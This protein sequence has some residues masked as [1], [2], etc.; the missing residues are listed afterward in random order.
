MMKKCICSI[1][2]LVAIIVVVA[3]LRQKNNCQIVAEP[4]P[5]AGYTDQDINNLALLCKIWGFMK[6]YHPSIR[7]GEYDWDKELFQIMPEMVSVQSVEERNQKLTDWVEKFHCQFETAT[8]DEYKKHAKMYPDILWIENRT[9]LGFELS[10]MLCEIRDAKRDSMNWYAQPIRKQPTMERVT[11]FNNELGYPKWDFPQI[12]MQLLALFRLWNAIQ[13]YYPYKYTLKDNWDKVLIDFIPI[14]IN[15]RDEVGYT[16]A[17]R[18]LLAS[19]HDSHAILSGAFKSKTVPTLLRFIEGKAVVV[20]NYKVTSKRRKVE[21][22][23]LKPGDV[24]ISVNSVPVDSLI[25]FISV[26]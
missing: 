5:E 26:W 14:F 4:M 24:V 7:N 10:E 2:V 17:L 12:N 8:W 11:D 15:V 3:L 9:L 25:K 20:R 22:D 1:S 18:R 13:Y 19:I 16:K 23:S 6:Y 21:R